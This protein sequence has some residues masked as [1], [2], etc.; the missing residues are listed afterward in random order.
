MDDNNRLFHEEFDE[1]QKHIRYKYGYYSFGLLM[2]LLTIN[3]II[4]DGLKFVYA[5]QGVQTLIVITIALLYNTIACSVNGATLSFKHGKGYIRGVIFFTFLAAA[6]FSYR[7]YQN[8]PLSNF[9]DN[10]M[11]NDRF[12]DVLWIVLCTTN[13][14][15]AYYSYLKNK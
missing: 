14:I 5:T 6:L 11:L 13:G 10:G 15:A 1:Y 4:V 9:F 12:I 8:L 3:V 2:V 7:V